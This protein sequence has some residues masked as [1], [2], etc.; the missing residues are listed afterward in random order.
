VAGLNRFGIVRDVTT[1]DTPQSDEARD[2]DIQERRKRLK[3]RGFSITPFV[4]AKGFRLE[5]NSLLGG[6]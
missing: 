1:L 6:Q 3:Q 5:N 2:E 4:E